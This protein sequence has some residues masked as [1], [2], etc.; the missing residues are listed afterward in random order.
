MWVGDVVVVWDNLGRNGKGNG[1]RKNML[2]GGLR[3]AFIISRPFARGRARVL[4]VIIIGTGMG[5]TKAY[6]LM[7]PEETLLM[8]LKLPDQ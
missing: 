4:L 3:A 7:P 2:L 5:I 1:R 6:R 8:L